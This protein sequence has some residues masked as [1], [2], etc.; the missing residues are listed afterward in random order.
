MAQLA[1]LNVL[2]QGLKQA[3]DAPGGKKR[4]AAAAL[5]T[6]FASL[7]LMNFV[8]LPGIFKGELLFAP[9][10]TIENFVFLALFSVSAGAAYSLFELKRERI[11]AIGVAEGASS[12]LAGV[13]ALF[14]SACGICAPLVLFYLG[15]PASFAF[16]PL[17]G[18]EFRFLSLGLMLAS[19]Y[20]LSKSIV[21]GEVCEITPV[22][23]TSSS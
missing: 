14:T 16:L 21:S 10:P 22:G 4:A 18:F 17:Q 19:V 23:A 9:D 20:Y 5:F 6:A 1:L 15:I 12:F 11:A 2:K 13:F 8:S 7:F 3:L